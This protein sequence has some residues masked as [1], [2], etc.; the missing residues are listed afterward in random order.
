MTESENY[1]DSLINLCALDP[2]KYGWSVLGGIK[3]VLPPHDRAR[4]RSTQLCFVEKHHKS[5][6]LHIDS[7]RLVSA[8]SSDLN[9]L[10]NETTVG[11]GESG[12][13]EDQNALAGDNV[14]G[15][16][17]GETIS[18]PLSSTKEDKS[19]NQII[20]ELGPQYEVSLRSIPRK[21]KRISRSK[22]TVDAIHT[23]NDKG[24]IDVNV[25]HRGVAGGEPRYRESG[26]LCCDTPQCDTNYKWEPLGTKCKIMIQFP[27][28]DPEMIHEEDKTK[29]E[30]IV[31][32]FIDGSNRSSKREEQCSHR[33]TEVPNFIGHIDWD[34]MDP[35]TPTP[36]VYASH[37][38]AEFGLS[39]GAILDLARSIQEQID[40]FVRKNF[41]YKV[42]IVSVVPLNPKCIG[43]LEPPVYANSSTTLRG[44]H[45]EA[46]E[47]QSNL[48]VPIPITC[49][50]TATAP[51][52]SEQKSTTKNVQKKTKKVAKPTKCAVNKKVPS[53]APSSKTKS[54][55]VP[56][57]TKK[58]KSLPKRLSLDTDKDNVN[59]LHCF[60][61]SELLELVQVQE[62]DGIGHFQ[63]QIGL[64]CRF[65]THVPP[66][67]RPRTAQIFPK[68][69]D[70][71]YRKVCIWQRVHF[72]GDKQNEPCPNIPQEIRNQYKMKK[73]ESNRRGHVTYWK[74]SALSLG[75]C[76]F[77]VKGQFGIIFTGD[78]AS[79]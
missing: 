36:I 55:N 76:D 25:Y 41:D 53:S 59:P 34:L 51:L 79:K 68:N 70:T 4:R 32:Q 58:S 45:C 20:W 24:E 48:V 47:K 43:K 23:I 31:T 9:E 21:K 28:A 75:L 73:E 18:R 49:H 3:D 61:R 46:S 8:T 2:P 29:N 7:S 67:L 57:T 74:Q 11:N 14:S 72:T 60:V 78:D 65:C 26:I 30:P 62:G 6:A 63:G 5:K 39:F 38:G 71:L 44:G 37:I 52:I 16:L 19:L 22:L 40:A 69:L 1:T 50:P 13:E 56:I 33:F 15:A 35:R 27:L 54:T 64:Q 10:N 66:N 77:N 12:V 17:K 42:P